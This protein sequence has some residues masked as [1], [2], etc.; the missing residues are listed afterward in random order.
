MAGRY[1]HTYTRRR[2]DMRRAA[3]R[4]ARTADAPD[5]KGPVGK[6]GSEEEGPAG[7]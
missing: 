5:E 6:E 1:D 4:A 7:A 2:R 3:E